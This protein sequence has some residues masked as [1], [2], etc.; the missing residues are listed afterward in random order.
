M[1]TTIEWFT[2][3]ELRARRTAMLAKAQTT[4][5]SLREKRDSYLA[6]RS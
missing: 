6:L 1:T 4:V 5:E 2:S 3:D